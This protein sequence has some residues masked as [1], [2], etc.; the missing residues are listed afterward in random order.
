M[1][2]V[3][4]VSESESEIKP[5]LEESRL[6][7]SWLSSDVINGKQQGGGVVVSG[8]TLLGRAEPPRADSFF[9]TLLTEP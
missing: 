2:S 7:V 5:S 1:S 8:L 3:A 6:A 9:L 4:S